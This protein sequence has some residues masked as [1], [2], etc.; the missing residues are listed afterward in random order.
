MSATNSYAAKAL[1]DEIE[2]GGNGFILLD[3]QRELIV[4]ALRSY[5]PSLPQAEVMTIR[6]A[7]NYIKHVGANQ[8]ER[9]LPHPQQWIVD[10]LE[11][12]NKRCSAT[13]DDHKEG[14]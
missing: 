8:T 1:A 9:G 7:L 13:H 11:D 6:A 2:N 5:G 12:I 14:K 4:K 3:E 10:E